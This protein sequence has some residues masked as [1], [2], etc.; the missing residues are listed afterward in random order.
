MRALEGGVSAWDVVCRPATGLRLLLSWQ[1]LRQHPSGHTRRLRVWPSHS[2]SPSKESS[3]GGNRDA[4]AGLVSTGFPSVQRRLSMALCN[5]LA[6]ETCIGR[7]KITQLASAAVTP[8]WPSSLKSDA[9]HP[10]E[11]NSRRKR[12]CITAG[13]CN[14]RTSTRRALPCFWHG[15]DRCFSKNGTNLPVTQPEVERR[16]THGLHTG[17]EP[18]LAG[19]RSQAVAGTWRQEPSE[20]HAPFSSPPIETC[21]QRFLCSRTTRSAASLSLKTG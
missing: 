15:T 1:S 7:F 21:L 12:N 9:F 14:C 18:A 4:P 13:R 11:Q 19:A 16:K 2:K 5:S 17:P 8:F 20:D 10:R 3:G 6:H